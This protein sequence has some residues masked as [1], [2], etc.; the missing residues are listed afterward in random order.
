[1]PTILVLEND[2]VIRQFMGL[3]LRKRGGY[4]VLEANTTPW[5]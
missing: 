5:R 3:V 1:M 4:T 2:P